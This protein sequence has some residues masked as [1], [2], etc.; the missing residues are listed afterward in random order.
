[1]IGRHGGAI[2]LHCEG[3]ASY[4]DG[5]PMHYHVRLPRGSQ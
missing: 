1:V 5:V 2:K 3:S 4:C